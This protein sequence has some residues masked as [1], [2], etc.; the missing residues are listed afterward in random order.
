MFKQTLYGAAFAVLCLLS[1]VV[2]A[3]G[4]GGTYTGTYTASEVPGNHKITLIFHQSGH[5]LKGHY[6]TA[7]GVYGK[8]HGCIVDGKAKM[9]W[10]N[11]TPK[12]PGTYVGV[13]KFNKQR[14][15]W[16]YSGSDC[17]G[18][19]KGKGDAKQVVNYP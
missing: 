19:E 4:V 3:T 2:Y 5:V 9:Y 13:Y 18:E 15:T 6:H 12:C 17:V 1:T 11:T 7:T 10:K 16:T 8:G 14:V